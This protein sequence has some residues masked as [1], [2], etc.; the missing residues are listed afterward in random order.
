V[1]A[2][3]TFLDRARDATAFD[4]GTDTLWSGWRGR[5]RQVA[6]RANQKTINLT[7]NAKYWGA[8]TRRPTSERGL[9]KVSDQGAETPRRE[10]GPGVQ[11][12]NQ[13]Q[14]ITPPPQIGT[15]RRESRVCGSQPTP[16]RAFK[17]PKTAYARRRFWLVNNLPQASVRDKAVRQAAR[18]VPRVERRRWVVEAKFRFREL[19]RLFGEARRP[20]PQFNSDIKP[21]RQSGI[22]GPEGVFRIPPRPG[23]VTT[24]RDA[25]AQGGAKGDFGQGT[26][27]GAKAGKRGSTFT[28]Q[29][30][31]QGQNKAS[32]V[33][34]GRSVPIGS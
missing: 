5:G 12:E 16:N 22:L 33:T 1:L 23:K 32:S 9:F 25:P 19:L 20:K 29:A 7:P 26:N 30:R 11:V 27:S 6:G 4:E 15:C 34:G 2:H 28:R 10:K 13:V 3:A 14:A 18:G 24:T 8:T 21:V 17:T 31:T